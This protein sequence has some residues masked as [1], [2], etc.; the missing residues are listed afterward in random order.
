MDGIDFVNMIRVHIEPVILV[1]HNYYTS[2][3]GNLIG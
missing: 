1:M 2:S 3:T